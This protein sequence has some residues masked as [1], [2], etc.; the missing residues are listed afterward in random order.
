MAQSFIGGEIEALV[1]RMAEENW[2]WG[3][4]RIQSGLSN[5]QHKPR[6]KAKVKLC[7][8]ENYARA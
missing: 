2:D 3:Q 4:R 5:L 6:P 7:L 8:C 1:V